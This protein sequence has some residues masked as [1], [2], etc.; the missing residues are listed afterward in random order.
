[1]TPTLADILARH[2]HDRARE[3]IGGI[4]ASTDDRRR[5]QVDLANRVLEV[6]ATYPTG[7][8]CCRNVDPERSSSG[9]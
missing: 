2:I 9:S 7:R 8:E 6:L 3:R 4:P 1:M 5:A